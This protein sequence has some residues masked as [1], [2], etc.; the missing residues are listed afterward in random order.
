MSISIDAMRLAIEANSPVSPGRG[1]RVSAIQCL[2][3]AFRITVVLAQVGSNQ[4]AGNIE[5]LQVEHPLRRG[6]GILVVAQTHVRSRQVSMNR[7]IV[8]VVQ[9]QVLG[10]VPG[11]N[12]LMLVE[13]EGHLGLAQLKILRRETEAG[14]DGFRGLAIVVW[15]RGLVRPADER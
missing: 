14:G 12:K 7:R 2:E 9:V 15:R 5:G 6:L 13:Q 8:G 11:A 4:Q 1:F 3:R 10:L